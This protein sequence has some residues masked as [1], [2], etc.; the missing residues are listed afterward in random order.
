MV[1]NEIYK[2]FENE[3]I[4]LFAK[5]CVENAP[6]YWHHVP[7]SSTGKYHPDYALGDGGLVR[8]TIALVKILNYLFEVESIANQFTSRERDLLRVAGLAHDMYKSGTQEEYENSKWTRFDHPLIAARNIQ[9][10]DGLSKDEKIFIGYAIASHMGAWNKDKRNPDIIL[11]KPENKYQIILH[12]ADYLA[13][14]KGIDI[15]FEDTET[16]KPEQE[17]PDIN[18]WKFPYGKHKGQTIP[19]V[20]ALDPGYIHWAKENMDKEPAKTLL[21]QI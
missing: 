12:L 3:D 21:K 18:S 13:S 1:F 15:K 14:R 10:I 11:P 6:D 16:I 5:K 19:E 4:T 9:K 7:A 17:V 2:S 8:H 20:L